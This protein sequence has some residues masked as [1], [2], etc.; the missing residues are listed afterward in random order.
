ML[1]YGKLCWFC[2]IFSI[3]LYAD[4]L[5]GTVDV[6]TYPQFAQQFE[7]FND[8]AMPPLN[9]S[10]P[11]TFPS[12]KDDGRWTAIE[13]VL[14]LECD[15]FFDEDD[16][17][18]DWLYEV[19][20][21]GNGFEQ[22]SHQP[23]MFFITEKNAVYFV[24]VS[25]DFKTVSRI[26]VARSLLGFLRTVAAEYS[27]QAGHDLTLAVHRSQRAYIRSQCQYRI[28][29]NGRALTAEQVFQLSGK[30]Q[31]TLP[32][33]HQL[34]LTVHGRTLSLAAIKALPNEEKQRHIVAGLGSDNYVLRIFQLHGSKTT[35]AFRHMIDQL[36][37]RHK[38]KLESKLA[39]FYFLILRLYIA[40]LRA[41]N[42]LVI[43]NITMSDLYLYGEE[44]ISGCVLG[45]VKLYY[46]LSQIIYFND[47]AS[48]QE[49]TEMLDEAFRCM[50]DN[51]LKVLLD[52]WNQQAKALIQWLKASPELLYK[53]NEE[54]LLTRWLEQ[55]EKV[56]GN[57]K[58]VDIRK[59]CMEWVEDW[60]HC[61]E[62]ERKKHRKNPPPV[63]MRLPGLSPHKPASEQRHK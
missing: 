29:L 32:P 18:E 31:H 43:G 13:H 57:D 46:L 52:Y 2:L 58:T 33:L 54:A 8:A 38:A 28:Y 1:Q 34:P 63:L 21:P 15:D 14:R 7:R 11:E 55:A 22:V 27:R 12:M 60:H 45:W 23:E 53:D 6:M 61:Y 16:N 56:F 37:Q 17:S 19:K 4:L 26:K 44:N 62:A 48:Q 3:Q 25:N 42:S 41:H 24:I 20:N 40:D 30:S 39:H 59:L 49:L 35:K 51:L 9:T 10:E 36:F 5:S 47:V 50:P